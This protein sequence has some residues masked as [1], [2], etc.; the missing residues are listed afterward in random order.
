L[1]LVEQCT[2]VVVDGFALPQ[3]LDGSFVFKLLEFNFPSK[4]CTSKA[5]LIWFSSGLPGGFIWVQLAGLLEKLV[6]N[7]QF[8]IIAIAF[9]YNNP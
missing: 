8:G 3:L 4:D 6:L 1:K 2:G 5:T 9:G 7:E